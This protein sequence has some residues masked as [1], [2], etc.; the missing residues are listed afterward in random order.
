[1]QGLYDYRNEFIRWGDRHFD[2]VE[3]DSYYGLKGMYVKAVHALKEKRDDIALTLFEVIIESPVKAPDVKNRANLAMARLLFDQGMY[4]DALKFYNQVK[5]IDLSYEQAQLLLEKAWTLYYLQHYRKAMGL[6][7]ALDAPSYK[8]FFVPDVYILRG[9][10]FKDLCHFIESKRVV[11]EFGFDYGRALDELKRRTPLENNRRVVD[12]ATQDGKLAR[13]SA[14]LRSLQAQRERIEDYES[15]W[16]DVGLDTHLRRLYDFETREQARLW[17]LDFERLGQ[18]TAQA[19]LE[20]EEQVNLLDYEVGLDIF[21]RI[22]A[23]STVQGIEERLVVPYDS[24]NVYY[25]FDTEYW[26]DELHSFQYFINSR[27]IEAGKVE[28]K[29]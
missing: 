26:N 5:Q 24:K 23:E 27:C 15:N 10:I 3:A 17:R 12:G 29:G 6:L 14:F 16:A 28:V 20:S 4:E 9:L 21:K 13:R 8:R 2:T 25:E 1:M 19:L 18:S 22:K 11:R 7:H